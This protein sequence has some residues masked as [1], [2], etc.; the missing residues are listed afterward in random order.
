MVIGCERYLDDTARYHVALALTTR[1]LEMH[2]LL[3]GVP[4]EARERIMDVLVRAL[5][6]IQALLAP[7]AQTASP[8][9]ETSSFGCGT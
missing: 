2:G 9:V 3:S 6:D 7:V 1:T 8:Q 5:D 4:E